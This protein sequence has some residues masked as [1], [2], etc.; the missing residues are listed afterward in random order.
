[1]HGAVKGILFGSDIT[2]GDI[3]I[4][5]KMDILTT[6]KTYNMYVSSAYLTYVRL[7]LTH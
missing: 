2:H 5:I 6:E 7:R 1:M 4:V 3:I